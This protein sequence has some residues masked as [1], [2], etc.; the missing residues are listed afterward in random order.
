M[1]HLDAFIQ[2]E[3]TL[4]CY[5]EHKVWVNAGHHVNN[6]WTEGTTKPTHPGLIGRERI[7]NA[8][9][10]ENWCFILFIFCLFTDFIS[11][12]KYKLPLS[13]WSTCILDCF[14]TVHLLELWEWKISKYCFMEEHIN[15]KDM[16][17]MLIHHRQ[18]KF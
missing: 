4:Y 2:K 3:L 10:T 5:N 17:W 11:W 16:M 15:W 8:F 14:E 12:K 13:N 6:R 18:M 1:F 7:F 9:H